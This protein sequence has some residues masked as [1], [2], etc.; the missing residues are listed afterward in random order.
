MSIC[1]VLGELN[2]GGVESYTILKPYKNREMRLSQ[3]KPII[4]G[5]INV[6]QSTTMSLKQR[7]L[8]EEA[9]IWPEEIGG[10]KAYSDNDVAK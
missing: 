3:F 6:G 1:K 4:W 5:G 9:I 7:L 8:E 2:L 10:S